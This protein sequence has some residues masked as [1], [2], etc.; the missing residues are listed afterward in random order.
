[1]TNYEEI[2]KCI[3]I[4]EAENVNYILLHCVSSYPLE[5]KFSKLNEIQNLNLKYNCPI[6]HSDHTFGTEI[7]GYAVAAGA[8]I[9]EKHFTDNIKFRLSDN[10]FSV[11][12]DE[13]I[14][15]KSIIKKV[16]KYLYNFDS[17]TEDFMRNFKKISE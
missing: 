14:E 4:L 3:E 1:M 15:I 6:G 13:V 2:N 11:T 8:K 17:S 12:H 5:K 16:H 10:F 7:V 9:I